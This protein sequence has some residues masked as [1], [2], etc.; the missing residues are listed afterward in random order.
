VDLRPSAGL[1]FSRGISDESYYHAR[2]PGE[3][4]N[5]A[6]FALRRSSVVKI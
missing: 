3:R 6:D 1:I 4:F 5:H 2:G